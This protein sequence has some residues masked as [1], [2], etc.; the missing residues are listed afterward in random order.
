MKK[1]PKT[2]FKK[3]KVIRHGS[4]VH[5]Y[6]G[7][8]VDFGRKVTIKELTGAA[9]QSYKNDFLREAK[10]W[11]KF[12]HNRL[13]RIEE[14]D[15]ARGWIVLE[16]LPESLKERI[17]DTP[18][19]G[20]IKQATLQILEGLSYLHSQG[21]LHC[22]L[23]SENIRF[24]GDNIKLTDGRGV[25]VNRPSPLP[26]P[27]G[28]NK[29]R[30]PEMLAGEFGSV[31]TATDI[32]LAAS[33]I[34]E[35]LAGNKFDSLF[36]SFVEGTPEPEAG[37][38]RWH[39]S[40]EQLE[41]IENLIPGL[42]SGFAKLLDGM[43]CKHVR[44]R[45]G[46][47]DE[48]IRELTNLEMSGTLVGNVE[49]QPNDETT[50]PKQP[51]PAPIKPTHEAKIQLI[52]RPSTPAYLRIASGVKAGTIFPM[53]LNNVLIGEGANCDVTLSANDYPTLRGREISIILGNSGWETK[54]TKRPEDSRETIFVGNQPCTSTLPVKSGDIIRL[55]SSGPDIQFVIQGKS[56]WTWQDVADELNLSK[57]FAPPKPS[58]KPKR[59]K[60][61]DLGRDSSGS[62]PRGESS[63]A[64]GPPKRAKPDAAA[65]SPRK[66]AEVISNPGMAEHAPPAP[67]S[68]NKK[69]SKKNR[70]SES[71][72][73]DF[74]EWLTDKDKLNW[75]ILIVGLIGLVI[76]IPLLLGGSGEKEDGK[77][78][79]TEL[80][81]TVDEDNAIQGTTERDGESTEKTEDAIVGIDKEEP[82]DEVN[83]IKAESGD[84]GEPTSE[85]QETDKTEGV[86]D[87]TDL[88]ESQSSAVPEV[89]EKSDNG[90]SDDGE[91]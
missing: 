16:F 79:K 50:S 72:F 47:A 6:E 5:V 82:V 46:T 89:E 45:I 10:R 54:E 53:E 42:P 76:F 12:E 2:N 63:A 40:K 33:V 44:N 61:E 49:D 55:S 71:R 37:W 87:S 64:P 75:L 3:S 8:H 21:W 28:S 88:Q 18:D 52:S 60:S 56:A 38:V 9:S 14:I 13:C 17:R 20:N 58:E 48:A 43:L 86:L 11:A 73:P 24:S 80:V 81:K 7:L 66:G 29:F 26:R 15:E 83:V 34:L 19:L 36:G 31:G 77:T 35:A 85:T 57:S 51:G 62:S 1:K 59:R 90:L 74:S 23:N 41:P 78:D 68:P 84:D 27:K 32:Y 39:N 30:A 22:N 25:A 91:E 65:H 67:P 4:Q 69:K 70:K